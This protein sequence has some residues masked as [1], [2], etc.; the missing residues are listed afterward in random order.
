MYM[1]STERMIT[2]GDFKEKQWLLHPNRQSF[3]LFIH[4]GNAVFIVK[5]IHLELS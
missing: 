1:Y 4:A 3:E 5:K 2:L